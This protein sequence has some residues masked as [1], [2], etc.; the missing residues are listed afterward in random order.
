MEL[1]P[2]LVGRKTYP[3]WFSADVNTSG[4]QDEV[5]VVFNLG[6]ILED[7][8]IQR[9]FIMYPEINPAPTLFATPRLTLVNNSVNIA[10]KVRAV[11]IPLLSTPGHFTNGVAGTGFN[12]QVY[13][14]KSLDIIV[15]A[16]SAFTLKVTDFKGAANPQL[17]TVAVQGRRRLREGFVRV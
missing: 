1:H 5:T 11:A 9:L 12:Q 16:R 14:S 17:I 6:R 8:I 3:N 13:N 15:K 7:Y 10:E 4:N 2:D